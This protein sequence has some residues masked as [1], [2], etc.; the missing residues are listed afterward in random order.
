MSAQGYPQKLDHVIFVDPKTG[1][2][3]EAF[4]RLGD[5]PT[6]FL[7]VLPADDLETFVDCAWKRFGESGP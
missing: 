6:S 4:R 3:I 7:A 2:E 5:K 1:E